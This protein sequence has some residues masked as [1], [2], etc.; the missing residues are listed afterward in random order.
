[1]GENSSHITLK[2]CWVK[3][4]KTY[5]KLDIPWTEVCTL[6]YSVVQNMNAVILV[7]LEEYHFWNLYFLEKKYC[8]TLLCRMVHL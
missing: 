5:E 7:N 8:E 6:S 1:M 2:A 4:V 3:H